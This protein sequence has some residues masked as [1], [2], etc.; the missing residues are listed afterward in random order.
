MRSIARL[1]LLAAMLGTSACASFHS[2]T[3]GIL[4]G[5]LF[6]AAVGVGATAVAGG[7]LATGAAV[8]GIV[9]TA[10]GGYTGCIN[11]GRCK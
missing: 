4:A 6:G 10:I 2:T 11:S 3:Q 9:G 8:G 7:S 5:G 1:A